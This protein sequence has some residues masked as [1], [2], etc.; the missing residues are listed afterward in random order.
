MRTENAAA[1]R[2]G[3]NGGSAT[4][5]GSSVSSPSRQEL[6]RGVPILV[7]EDDPAGAKLVTLLLK[8]QGAYV[9]MTLSAEEA[10]QVLAEFRPRLIVLDLVLPRMGG[11]LL[12]RQIK[13]DPR[14]SE[15]LIV[16]TT[17][18]HG[19]QMERV[20]REH[21]CVAYIRKPIDTETFVATLAACLADKS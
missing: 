17:S 15:T 5:G 11:L 12:A 13:A 19:P 3:A 20:V 14:L 1:A 9:R 10:L 4:G 7:V 2:T 18:I 8:Q 6:L 21:G 16:A